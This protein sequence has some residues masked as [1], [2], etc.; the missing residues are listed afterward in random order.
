[1]SELLPPL[2][3]AKIRDGLVD[4]LTTSFALTDDTAATGLADFLE[5]PAHGIFR[6]PYIRTRL[7]FRPAE[8]GW[9]DSLDW[10][11]P[12]TPYRHQAT[13]YQR[14]ST[15][16][17]TPGERP[18]PTIVTTGTGSGKTEAFLNPILDHVLRAR[19]L[20]VAGVK[21]LIIY[22]MNALANDQAARLA[23]LISTHEQLRG[24]TAA[25]FVG[26]GEQN[27]TLVTENGL[28]TSREAIRQQAPDI[29]LTNY[30]M[31]DQLLLRHDDQPIWQQSATSLRYVVLDEF[32]TYDG[33]QGTDVAMLLRRLGLALKRHWADDDPDIDDTAR[34]RPLGLITPVATSATLGDDRD[35][36]AI[37]TFAQ[38]V[39]GEPF[40]EDCVITES[41]LPLSEWAAEAG[42]YKPIPLHEADLAALSDSALLEST[43]AVVEKV[44]ATLFDPPPRELTDARALLGL[45]TAHPAFRALVEATQQARPIDELADEL[46]PPGTVELTDAQRRRVIEVLIA[47][48]GAVRAS[49]GRAAPSTE[50]NL[51]VRELTRIDRAVSLQPEFFWS[52]DGDVVTDATDQ[53]TLRAPAIYCRHC[54][55]SGWGV[56]LAA[57]GMALADGANPRQMHV[58][59]E[60]RFRP[61]IYAAA[62]V[63]ALAAGE[64]SGLPKD[65]WWLDVTHEQLTANAPDPD[66]TAYRDGRIVP[67]LTHQGP[68]AEDDSL[69]DVCPACLQRDGIRFLGTATAT[70]LSVALSILFGDP[71]LDSREKKSLVFT[72]SV[73]DAAHRAGFIES[74]SRT[75]SLRAA[76]RTALGDTPRSLDQLVDDLVASAET[77]FER[78]R[79]VPPDLVGRDN[80][81]SFWRAR[82]PQDIPSGARRIVKN[83]LLFD[84]MLE[85]GL[86]STYGRTL[87]TTGSIGVM[88]D[89][90]AAVLVAAA[91]KAWQAPGETLAR[92][93]AA[94]DDARLL[95]WA[96]GVLEQIRRRG[97]IIHD[98]LDKYLSNDGARIFIWGKRRR[99]DGMPAFPRGRSA[100][101]FPTT[102]KPRPNG[103][104]IFDQVTSSPGWY[105]SWTSRLLHVDKAHAA[106]LA[107]LLLRELAQAD[108]LAE[109][110][111]TSNALVWGLRPSVILLEPLAADG[112][113]TLVCSVCHAELPGTPTSIDRLD[114]APCFVTRCSGMMHRQ[115]R[116]DNF[117]R[118][119]YRSPQMRRI[120]AR[121]HSSLVEDA[122]RLAYEDGFRRSTQDAGAPNVL[123]ATPTLEMGIDIGDLSTVVLS[124][125]PP[126]VASYLQRVGRAGR[127]TGNALHLA[128]VTGRG[129]QLAALGDP[130]ATINGQVRPPATYLNA[131]EILRR[132]YLAAVIDGLAGDASTP[133]PRNA[134]GALGST[135]SDKFLGAVIDDAEAGAPQRL[136]QF[137]GTFDG[138]SEDS[139]SDLTE[140]AAPETDGTGAVI[141]RSSGLAATLATASGAWL[142][143]LQQ[144]AFRRK[145]VNAALPE[146]QAA[147]LAEHAEPE[148]KTAYRSAQATAA[149]LGKMIENQ[150]NQHWVSALESRGVLP[151]YTLIDDAV[152]LDV[153]VTWVDPDTGS[154]DSE[155]RS[156]ERASSRAL[157]ELAPG[158][159]F[160]AR[161]LEM[162][163]DGI[164][165]GPESTGIETRAFCGAC[166]YSQV[167]DDGA[168]HQCPRCSS[169]TI[170]DTSMH[171]A[172]VELSRVF[173]EVRR[174]EARIADSAEDRRKVQF[175]VA[176]CADLDPQLARRQWHVPATGLGIGHYSSLPIRWVNTGRTQRNGATIPLA[177]QDVPTA[178]FEIC[179]ECGKA[180]LDP[181]ANS[182]QEH[183]AWC[184]LRKGSGENVCT[185]ALTRTLTTEA[186][187]VVLPQAVLDSELAVP[188]LVAALL[189]GLREDVGGSP[190]HLRIE[191]I[192]AP[193]VSEGS[194]TVRPALLVHDIVP[195]G[196]G[197]LADLAHPDAIWRVLSRAHDVLAGCPCAEDDHA[198]CPRCLMSF[199]SGPLAESLSRVT[200]MRYLRLMLGLDNEA[201]VDPLQ[202]AWVVE[203]SPVVGGNTESHLE[204][205]F[206]R[207]L[208]ELLPNHG[209][210]VKETHGHSGT[211]LQVS[212]LGTPWSIRPQPFLHGSKPDFLV[213]G[214]GSPRRIAI[215]TDGYAFHASQAHNN[216]AD[217]AR[218][219][220]VLRANGIDVLAV[221]AADLEPQVAAA[222]WLTTGT[223]GELL[224]VPAD[225]PGGGMTNEAIETL[226]GGP[227]TY[228]MSRLATPVHPPR[229]A[230]SDAVWLMFAGKADHFALSESRDLRSLAL[231]LMRGDT[232]DGDT[233][234]WPAL[235]WR[236]D[237]VGVLV[238]ADP[239]GRLAHLVVVLD[240]SIEALNSPTFKTAW[241]QWLH[242]SNAL[243]DSTHAIDITTTSLLESGGVDLPPAD[244]TYPPASVW[245]GLD[246]S[247]YTEQEVSVFA[248]L[249]AAGI[250]A[251]ELGAEV[252]DGIPV[253]A[254]WRA[255]G[256]VLLLH[257]EADDVDDLEAA[258]LR[259]VSGHVDEV[260]AALEE[261]DA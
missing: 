186:L 228:L 231:A 239:S 15:R 155:A 133:R 74:R 17:L 253:D 78:Y 122:D 34:G 63:A 113:E 124:S 152:R 28:V 163:V 95:T 39:F 258:G 47:F 49:A 189:L 165:L 58:N 237:E 99:L 62:E 61:L 229:R 240:D 42:E 33:A 108:V 2:M 32:H 50:V 170:G 23:T 227:L 214:Q 234:G 21:A 233:E 112:G 182:P 204:L 65:V 255:Q 168:P 185:V 76:I 197:Y 250:P 225:H 134:Q 98:W 20:G 188:N 101:T 131:A 174:D 154:Y 69:A 88:V 181:R 110:S 195:G 94:P 87:E 77:P 226:R 129:R 246:T 120:V 196:T 172:T 51:W 138:L 247:T 119:L 249:D 219:R 190:D 24:V 180:D 191:P 12:F 238:R 136:A 221:T 72:D 242:L 216:L 9:Q 218:K 209:A 55:R 177:G 169:P 40:T 217:D 8:D 126:S 222:G 200:A 201:S 82:R 45:A 96:R 235:W 19:R 215:F 70:L 103:E 159:H 104:Q 244:I 106:S 243:I 86:Q 210:K 7:P 150:R 178:G 27:R 205:Q 213:E 105:V 109:R 223:I 4:Y 160:Y 139:V 10:T 167:L 25:I 52:D 116:E 142:A 137:L 54:G 48:L 171:L 91:R 84:T 22:P 59:R 241:Q 57:T 35:P 115:P 252:A 14:L 140:W 93:I 141:A 127:L 203:N 80:V 158:A 156:F 114:G 202:P 83:R 232:A 236:Q 26:S 44:A 111:T 67:I 130:L 208:L 60:G 135:D 1:M 248:Q 68:D 41:R 117:Y 118:Q 166:G 30:K 183:R 81:D 147:A 179:A 256:V 3:A 37:L 192:M 176:V 198:A 5:H 31:L 128:F 149:Q 36:S 194:E 53:A 157:R 184:P 46:L 245:G 224:A 145:E 13:A 29:L 207:R 260:R 75:L 162:V 254:A 97:G 161:G 43:V 187:V 261:G 89:A 146:L 164:D 125:M 102:A 16:H 193:I 251:P 143:E 38:T 73:Q 6:G 107:R 259:V 148:E 121:E 100:P 71:D 92:A 153:A 173:S 85:V 206:R 66:D 11:P 211:T 90:P 64:M 175:G 212:G 132:Q 144:A 123:V 151:N 199:V 257:P 56:A 220:A 79:L 230:V 18:K